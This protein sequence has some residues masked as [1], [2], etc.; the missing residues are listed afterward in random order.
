MANIPPFPFPFKYCS[1]ARAAKLFGCLEEDIFH[2]LKHR[3]IKGFFDYSLHY[4]YFIESACFIYSKCDDSKVIKEK[5]INKA[6]SHSGL[7]L[8]KY[9]KLRNECNE[10]EY[11]ELVASIE[12]SGFIPITYEFIFGIDK[13]FSFGEIINDDFIAIFQLQDSLYSEIQN[14]SAENGMAE[15]IFILR[16]DLT[17]IHKSIHEGIDM[18][19]REQNAF[20]HAQSA[21]NKIE[22]QQP[23]FSSVTSSESQL[24]ALGVMAH[25][26]NKNT[27]QY[28]YGDKLSANSLEKAINRALDDNEMD[29]I[30][31]NIR[32]DISR[33]YQLFL[34][35]APENKKQ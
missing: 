26:L 22:E 13:G 28:R 10:N 35:I 20:D 19:S 17:S 9:T 7:T 21:L 33:G 18:L 2:L 25:L 1:V 3:C 31:Q 15:N 8:T 24:I 30:P 11:I 29:P 12:V 14:N 32:K 34:N 4:P 16:E 6:S 23:V 5:I 27:S